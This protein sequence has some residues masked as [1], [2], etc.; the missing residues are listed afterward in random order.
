MAKEKPPH[1]KPVA[2]NNQSGILY[3]VIFVFS[4]LIY[5]NSIFNNYNLDDELVTENHRLTKDGISAIPSILTEPYYKDK[6]GYSY[7][8]RPVVLISFAV[9]HSLFGE[10][11]HISHFINVLLYS[12][13]CVLLFYVLALLLNSCSVI[14]P[15]LITIIFAAHPIHTE[16]VAS[17]KNRDEIFA[18]GFAL[19]ALLSALRFID[20]KKWFY[21]LLLALAFVASLLSKQTTNVFIVFIPVMLIVFRKI[22]FSQAMLLFFMLVAVAFP[23]MNI[24]NISGKLKIISA[25]FLFVS[26]MFLLMNNFFSAEGFKDFVSKFNQKMKSAFKTDAVVANANA[27]WIAEAKGFL[28]LNF[29]L[30]YFLPAL[31]LTSL[32]FYGLF[33]HHLVVLYAAVVLLCA[34]FY[35]AN[36]EGKTIVLLSLASIV[37]S[38]VVIG[39]LPDK[40][41][42]YALLTFVVLTLF[43]S[44]GILKF[45]SAVLALAV[46]ALLFVQHDFRFVIILMLYAGFYFQQLRLLKFAGIGILVATSLLV[47][48]KFFAHKHGDVNFLLLFLPMSALVWF[49]HF[50][51]IEIKRSLLTI[52]VFLFA[53]L[54]LSWNQI[55]LPGNPVEIKNTLTKLDWKNPVNINP[56]NVNR[57]LIFIE[58]PVGKTE[59]FNIQL[60]TAADILLKYFKLILVPYPMSFYY[61]YS[62]ITAHSVTDITSIIGLLLY[63]SLFLLSVFLMKKDSVTAFGILFFIFCIS[64]YT[65]IVV[66]VPGMMADRFLFIPSLG[67]AFVIASL[68]LKIFKTDFSFVQKTFSWSSISSRLRYSIITLLLF[69][70]VVVI[71]RNTDWKDHLTLFR[72]DISAVE[73]SAQAQ[74]LLGLY[75]FMQSKDADQMQRKQLLEEAAVHFKKALEVYPNYLNPAYDLGKVYEGLGQKD[76]AFAQYQSAMKIDTNF[77]APCFSMAVMLHNKGKVEE[78]IYYYERYVKMYTNDMKVY[79]NLSLAYYSL[80]QFDK[81]IETNHRALAANPNEVEPLINIAKTYRYLNLTDSAIY[82]YEKALMVSPNDPRAFPDYQKLKTQQV[83][84]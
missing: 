12:L 75:A 45:I 35:F 43:N 44:K 65:N 62:Y 13:L 25:A 20:S 64:A 22:K 4:F 73:N 60:G 31:V 10:N 56:E 53:G 49:L 7:E 55:Q 58:N 19:L 57:P 6:S 82:Y 2:T 14:L 28:K 36:A 42:L 27:Q 34:L 37:I 26:F 48:F 46:C 61:G 30:F 54:A 47:A 9:E 32:G 1:K 80:K 5:A 33:F 59:P 63:F 21:L 50:R 24:P 3:A 78:A 11:P 52:Y 23:V 68:L 79:A 18:V 72:H 41:L 76:E 69:Y 8:Y 38:V 77:D 74:N 84:Q 66:P 67:F 15:F 16:I 29:F 71:S 81:S 39:G 51:K 40:F 17:I 70:S 83:S